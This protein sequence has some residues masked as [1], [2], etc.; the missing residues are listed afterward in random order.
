MNFAIIIIVRLKAD[1]TGGVHRNNRE[2]NECYF[3]KKS[4]IFF[5]NLE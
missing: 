3:S 1:S 4:V 5:S 2:L